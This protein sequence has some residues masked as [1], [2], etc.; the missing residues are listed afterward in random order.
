MSGLKVTPRPRIQKKAREQVRILTLDIETRPHAAYVFDLW[1]Q[2]IGLNQL[3][4]RGHVMCFVAKWYGEPDVIFM[5]DHHDGHEAMIRG[6]WAL[7]NEADAIVT[8][9]GVPFDIPH[10][11]REFA[12]LGMTPPSPHK[13]IDLLKTVRKRFNFS[14]N[15]LANVVSELGVGAK[16][17]TGGFELWRGCMADDPK[18][19]ERMKRYNE[20]DVKVTERLYD[21]LR[22]W[23]VGH[24]HLGMFT[25]VEWSCPHCGHEDVS[26]NRQGEARAFVQA[27]RQYQ[28]VKCGTWIRGNRKLQSPVQTRHSK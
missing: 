12:L 6:A 11:M 14:S 25:A 17:E 19:W 28:C 5:S 23:I 7:L 3:M 15:K 9:N 18:A 10:L 1:K 4:E 8:Y 24:P 2:N 21:R 27:Y 13:D 16:L 26:N 20:T 22:P